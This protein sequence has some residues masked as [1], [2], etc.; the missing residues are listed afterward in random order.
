MTLRQYIGEIPERGSFT[1]IAEA[2]GL[3]IMTVR[4]IYDGADASLSAMR[5]IQNAIQKRTPLFA[6]P[7]NDKGKKRRPV[8]KSAKAR[9]QG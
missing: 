6:K 7:R 4:R 2:S 3:S 5:K 9:A 8:R 1:R